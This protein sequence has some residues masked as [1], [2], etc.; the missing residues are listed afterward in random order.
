MSNL[1]KD[2]RPGT[3]VRV[4]IEDSEKTLNLR[5]LSLTN[6]VDGF[7]KYKNMYK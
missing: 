7:I 3:V 2:T 6:V 5:L 1:S 4:A